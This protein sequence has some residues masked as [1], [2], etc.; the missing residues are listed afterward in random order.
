M[1]SERRKATPL[2]QSE[3]H[4]QTPANT[5]V[6]GEQDDMLRMLGEFETG[7]GSLKQLFIQRQALQSQ[8]KA[9]EDE[10]AQRDNQLA[11][12]T[13]ELETLMRQFEAQAHELDA[14]RANLQ[15]R[16]DELSKQRSE[17][18]HAAKATQQ[19][20]ER[21]K[22]AAQAAA[23]ELNK[24]RDALAQQSQE[25]SRH[26]SELDRR[27]QE[28]ATQGQQLDSRSKELN[29]QAKAV[30][31]ER[32]QIDSLRTDLAQREQQLAA[33]QREF[34]D[35]NSRLAEMEQTLARER[36]RHAQASRQLSEDHTAAL[37]QL[38]AQ[39]QDAVA[40]AKQWQ[41]E[42]QDWQS[43]AQQQ[44]QRATTLEQQLSETGKNAQQHERKA[45]EL[46]QELAASRQQAAEFE[47]Q[48]QY[49]Q[50]VASD[51]SEKFA[52]VARRFDEVTVELK[53]AR[54]R[55]AATTSELELKSTNAATLETRVQEK[56]REVEQLSRL[57]DEVRAH[58]ASQTQ[59]LTE[60]ASTMEKQAASI[61][62]LEQELQGVRSGA[63]TLEQK[64]HAATQELAQLKEKFTAAAK[65][66]ASSAK[67]ASQR[68]EQNKQL[69]DQV[70]NLWQMISQEQA[71]AADAATKWKTELEAKRKQYDESQAQL[72][73]RGRELANATR[74]VERLKN[75]AVTFAREREEMS[76]RYAKEREQLVADL[77]ARLSEERLTWEKASKVTLDAAVAEARS[78]S[79]LSVNE[80]VSEL[81]QQLDRERAEKQHWV[82]NLRDVVDEYEQ[83]WCIERGE[84][85]RLHEVATRLQ[86]ETGEADHV[87][88]TLRSKLREEVEHRKST[89]E[90][91][92]DMST[93]L[94]E[95][96]ARVAQLENE[97]ARAARTP[98]NE[99]DEDA[100]R[101][102]LAPATSGWRSAESVARRDERIR[103]MRRLVRDQADKVRKGS[104]ALRRRYEQTEQVLKQRAELASARQRII[105]AEQRLQSSK[106]KTKSSVLTLSAVATV[107]ILGGLSWALAQQVAPARF[108]ATSMISADGR[109]RELN[110]KELAEWKTY[111]EKVLNDPRF[112]QMASERY[113][114]VGM[115]ELASPAAVKQ[116][117]DTRLNADQRNPGEMVLTLTGYGSTRTERELDVL[118]VAFTSQANA[119]QTARV[120]GSVTKIAQAS[121]T[122][123]E[124]LD[125]TRLYWAL[126][127]LG[128]GL[129]VCFGT[130]LLLWK[131]LA[132]AKTKFEH[133]TQV[134]QL[135]D[136]AKW[137]TPEF[138]KDTEVPKEQQRKA[139]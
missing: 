65:D 69:E 138:I 77:Q 4:A 116:L 112:H 31:A 98:R 35:A 28:L 127:M 52:R 41:R 88:A 10:L 26:A 131:K 103:L 3:D 108:M 121:K 71:S 137:G 84:A 62:A 104:E 59:S 29:A 135:L 2:N 102:H 70:G 43:Q 120:D 118:T 89:R 8:L 54:E 47:K 34:G 90:Q 133:D 40:S 18:E 24:Q 15:Q 81:T 36:E 5:P 123:D 82:T 21:D 97:L 30:E 66:A 75:E 50:H 46:S 111:H 73:A 12:K 32:M 115:A 1:A 7:L 17:I 94:E 9:R 80:Q 55:L 110:A 106:A 125:N 113:G 91:I 45:Q 64:L 37:K 51:A 48:A 6:S 38:D 122:G 136:D 130:A 67:S 42:T 58:N 25:L 23:A 63:G 132:G 16:E 114:R 27:T 128:T 129:V 14:S 22:A 39:L 87:V 19:E 33:A 79:Q 56:S 44:S 96:A 72:D 99:S 78:Q 126:A 95:A 57:L 53:D 134:A 61:A 92:E 139:A 119:A 68:R 107:A 86:S 11:S 13:R 124:P 117:I 109:G 85:A 105:D 83:L 60:H 20:R 49:Q 74:E 101:L 93:R 76:A 100:P